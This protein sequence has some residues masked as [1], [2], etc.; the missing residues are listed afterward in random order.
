[1]KFAI[2]SGRQESEES[3]SDDKKIKLVVPG[4]IRA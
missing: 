3:D 2:P 4:G 1:M